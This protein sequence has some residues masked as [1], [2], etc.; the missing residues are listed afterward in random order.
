[1][2]IL[3]ALDGSETSNAAVEEVASRPWPA[4]SSIKLLAVLEIP[5]TPTPETWALPNSYY[6]K[7]EEAAQEQADAAINAATTA[8]RNGVTPDIEI[9][10]ITRPGVAKNEIL[11][12][13]ENWGADLI[14]LGSHGYKGWQ[15]FLLGSV[16][17]AV[18]GHAHCSVLIV[19]HPE[20][21]AARQ[22]A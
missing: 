11:T 14:V 18:A 12:E 21:K 13:A 15:R 5:F 16:S 7:I 22:T 1:M 9:N 20:A 19:R 17:Q 4:G 8:L 10:A 3:I 6:T 2:K